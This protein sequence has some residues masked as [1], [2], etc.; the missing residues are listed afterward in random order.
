VSDLFSRSQTLQRQ[1][2]ALTDAAYVQIDLVSPLR[3]LGH[4]RARATF[5]RSDSGVLRV[6]MEIPLGVDFPELLAHELEH[7]LEQIEGVDLSEMARTR[8][9]GV[10]EVGENVFETA[11]AK[12]AGRAAAWEVATRVPPRPSQTS[13]L[14]LVWD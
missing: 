3:L 5:E 1:C 4:C 2:R 10:Q 14:T 7:V 8:H 6:L 12:A 9:T 11:R 13:A